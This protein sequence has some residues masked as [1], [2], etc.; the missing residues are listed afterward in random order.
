MLLL[1]DNYDSFTFNLAHYLLALGEDVRVV[2]ND[3]VT[4]EEIRRMAPARIVISPGPGRPSDAGITPR[5]F[6]LPGPIFGVC[7][8]MQA[9][10]E[11]FGARI[12]HAP[13]LV[14]GKTR[15]VRHDGLGV[16]AVLPSPFAA[17]RYHSLC[18]DPSSLPACL[19][20]TARCADGTIMGLRHR[21]RPLE[22]VQFH[23]EAILTEHGSDLLRQWLADTA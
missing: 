22:G 23:P 2:R 6:E 21:Q 16:F 13:E 10:A 1:I 20:V 18:V 14:H 3:T 15:E 5:L 17:T 19:E 4:L 12:I 7:L 8:G 9:L 11:Y